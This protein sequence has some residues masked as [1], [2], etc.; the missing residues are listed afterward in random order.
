MLRITEDSENG[1]T[2]RLRLDG[3]VN[4]VSTLNWKPPVYA[5]KDLPGKSSWWTWQGL[6][7]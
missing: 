3:T 4:A 5:I 7:S 1:K 2:V 6:Y